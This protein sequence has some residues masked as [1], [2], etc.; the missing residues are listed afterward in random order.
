MKRKIVPI[1]IGIFILCVMAFVQS[2]RLPFMTRMKDRLENLL[3]DEILVRSHDGPQSSAPSIVI[4]DIDEKSIAEIGRWPWPR[5]H[6]ID[7][8]K[9]VQSDGAT[10]IAFD[11][12]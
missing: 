7:L 6:M 9:T 4:V 8:I 2:T 5:K 11:M 12:V 1:S 3:Y 10:L